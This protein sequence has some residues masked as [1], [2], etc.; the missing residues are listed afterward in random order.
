MGIPRD[1]N[2]PHQGHWIW[3]APCCMLSFWSLDRGGMGI[4]F[5]DLKLSSIHLQ[6]CD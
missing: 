6:E 3:L 4:K 5:A 2:M 1:Q